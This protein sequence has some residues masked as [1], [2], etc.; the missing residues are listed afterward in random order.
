MATFLLPHSKIFS[1][2]WNKDKESGK[3]PLQRV[4]LFTGGEHEG[5]NHEQYFESM[6]NSRWESNLYREEIM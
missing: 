6:W 4:N 5:Y 2:S 3:V 1:S